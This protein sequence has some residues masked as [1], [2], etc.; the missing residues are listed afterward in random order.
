[1]TYPNVSKDS[2]CITLQITITRKF[3]DAV[4]IRNLHVYVI[5]SYAPDAQE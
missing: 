4:L 1:M 5:E 2:I 3:T